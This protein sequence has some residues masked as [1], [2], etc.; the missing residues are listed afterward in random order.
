MAWKTCN[1]GHRFQKTSDCPVCP[2]CWAGYY[3]GA[4]GGAFP[5]LGAPALRALLNARITDLKTLATYREAEI[6]A[7]HGMGPSSL[8]KLRRYLKKHGL[9]FRKK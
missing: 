4:K 3:K 2:K 7:L 8:P 6:L 1:R 5:G 9:A